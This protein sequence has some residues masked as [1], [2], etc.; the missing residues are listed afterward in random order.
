[1]T[2]DASEE[3][4]YGGRLA[5]PQ[6][7]C[8]STEF[9]PEDP[10]DEHGPAMCLSCGESLPYEEFPWVKKFANFVVGKVESAE[11]SGKK[12]N[13]LQVRIREEE[14]DDEEDKKTLL[15]IVTNDVK[16]KVGE[17]V[18]VAQVG[19]I[20]PAGKSVEDG[21]TSVQKASVGGSASEGM[22]C[23]STMLSW[24]GG[25]KGVAVRLDPAGFPVGSK[26]PENRP[27]GGG[28]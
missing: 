19:A 26:P 24:V 11:P 16:V 23:D 25:A 14:N 12:L 13:K 5:C 8:G 28:K 18:V 15:T 10:E 6:P 9:E 7:D 2:F 17:H 27:T 4:P 20:V 3:T 21:G 1:M 22:L